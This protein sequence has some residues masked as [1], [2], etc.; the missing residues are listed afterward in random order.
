LNTAVEAPE[1][2]M[3][4]SEL[5]ASRVFKS[6]TTVRRRFMRRPIIGTVQVLDDI[7][8]HAENGEFVSILGPSGCGKSTLLRIFAGLISADSGDVLVGGKPVHGPSR[9][10]AVVFQHVGL[11]PWRT[12]TKNVELAFELRSHKPANGEEKGVVGKYLDAVGLTGFGDHYP[13]Q[14]SGGMQQRVGIARALVTNPTIMLLDEPFGALDAQTR[15]LMQEELLRIWSERKITAVL[16]THDIE[17]AIFLSDRVL[18]MT[19][20]PGRIKM[21]VKVDLPRPRYSYDVRSHP[22]FLDLK[23]RL[24][25]SIREENVLR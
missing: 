19:R 4:N 2:P 15:M 25:D 16:V 23:K 7:A 1:S 14:L 20:R 11:L 17:E 12:V 8:L 5:A 13:H 3:E 24:W 6:F 9:A 22:I 10:V 21:E 18:V